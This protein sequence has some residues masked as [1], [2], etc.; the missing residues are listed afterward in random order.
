M[1]E[2]MVTLMRFLGFFL[3]GCGRRLSC[4]SRAR[5]SPGGHRRRISSSMRS[6]ARRFDTF[7]PLPSPSVS[8]SPTVHAVM[9]T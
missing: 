6:A 7:L 2:N 8:M 5:S 9:N 4:A 1:K 3:V